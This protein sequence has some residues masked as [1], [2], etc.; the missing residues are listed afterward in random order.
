MLH[1][2]FM[3]RI[4]KIVATH[5]LQ[6]TLILTHL[7]GNSNW[8]KNEQVIFVAVQKDSRIPYYITKCKA[9]NDEE[10]HI[11]LDDIDTVES[12]KK[13]MGKQVYVPTEIL[14]EA[15]SD[16]PLLWIGFNVVDTEKGSLGALIDI[17]QTGHQWV[18]TIRY[19]AKEVLLPMV[20]PL[21]IEVNL[22]NK[23]IRMNLPE[24][25]LDL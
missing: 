21:L 3:I 7:V 23:Y 5:G 18:G 14:G 12:A 10:Y 22:R 15:K 16:S 9:L 6:G 24:G 25:L 19:N 13:L 17:A 8:L 2:T 20:E 11:Q 4:G 1:L